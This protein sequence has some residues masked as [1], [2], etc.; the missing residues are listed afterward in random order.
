MLA[1]ARVIL[2]LALATLLPIRLVFR[3]VPRRT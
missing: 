2:I 3:I 1:M